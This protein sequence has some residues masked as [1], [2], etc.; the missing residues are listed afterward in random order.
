VAG[1]D[2][3]LVGG[4]GFDLAVGGGGAITCTAEIRHRLLEAVVE[5]RAGGV[6]AGL[7]GGGA[8]DDGHDA[9]AVAGGGGGEAPAGFVGVAGL[10]AVGA[11]VG[12]QQVVGGGQL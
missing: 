10:D 1:V 9:A 2:D 3:V 4:L 6:V 5:E 11:R 12:T 7:F 8:E